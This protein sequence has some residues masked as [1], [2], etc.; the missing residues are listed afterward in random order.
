MKLLLILALTAAAVSAED[1]Q[2]QLEPAQTQVEFTLSDVLHTVHGT[3]KLKQSALT[4]NPTQG[5]ASGTLIVDAASGQSGSEARDGRMKKNILEVAH[6]P[7][8]VFVANHFT[9]EYH[10]ASDSDVVLHG[11]LR[12]H[13]ADHPLD[14]AVHLHSGPENLSATTQ[15]DVPYVKWGMKNPSTL[16]LRVGDTVKINIHATARIARN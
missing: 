11:I 15:F 10:A 9:G 6:Y 1:L 4:F 12:I 5:T 2:L 3:F 16:F 7:E 14:L 13:G 8:I